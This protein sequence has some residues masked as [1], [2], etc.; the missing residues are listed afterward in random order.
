MKHSVSVALYILFSLQ[1]NQRLSYV[2]LA[3]R[4]Q[5]IKFDRDIWLCSDMCFVRLRLMTSLKAGNAVL[6]GL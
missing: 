5:S 2:T 3:F 4:V 1:L 6:D